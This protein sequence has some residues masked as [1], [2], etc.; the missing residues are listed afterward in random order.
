MRV[1]HLVFLDSVPFLPFAVRKLPE[2]F[3]LSIANYW[4]THYINTRANLDYVG[5]IP[6]ITYNGVD[7]M[8]GSE[9]NEFLAWYEGQKHVVFD[10]IR[11]QETYCQEDVSVLREVSCVLRSEFLHIGNIDV[12]LESVT[13]ASACNKVIRKRLLKPNTICL[14]PSGG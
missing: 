6:D 12:F 5:K 3:G 13:I 4:Y 7:E 2:S 11:V 8:S 14:I 10:N 9:R 1:E